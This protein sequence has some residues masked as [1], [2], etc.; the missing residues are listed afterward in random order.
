[1]NRGVGIALLVIGL[2]A[3]GTF[4]Y[5]LYLIAQIGTCASGVT[6]YVIAHQCPAGTGSIIW[7]LTGS[8]IVG[9][10]GLV[11]VGATLGSRAAAVLWAAL[12]IPLGVLFFTIARAAPQIA[13][14]FYALCALFVI[15][16]ATPL[17]LSAKALES[18][19]L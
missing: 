4:D 19:N 10:V 8:L 18:W 3:F 17:F 7:L 9:I 2:A 11:G 16:G 13:V 14:A 1:M 5:A 6:P 12:F 15:M